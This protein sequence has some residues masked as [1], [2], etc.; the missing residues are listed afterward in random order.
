MTH[1]RFYFHRAEAA[2]KLLRNADHLRIDLY[3]NDGELALRVELAGDIPADD[4]QDITTAVRELID[5]FTAG[6]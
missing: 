3:S 6:K 5:E 2:E 1:D 4:A